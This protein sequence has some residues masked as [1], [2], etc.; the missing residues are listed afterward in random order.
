M[1]GHKTLYKVVCTNLTA[2]ANANS[3]IHEAQIGNPND[4]YINKTNVNLI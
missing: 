1:N 3:K 2:N 4:Q